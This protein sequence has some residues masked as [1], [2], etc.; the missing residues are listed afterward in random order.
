MIFNDKPVQQKLTK[1]HCNLESQ[2]ESELNKLLKAKIIFPIRHSK[3][4]SS[5]VPIQKNNGDIHICID[6]RNIVGLRGPGRGSDLF[7][8]TN[9]T[10]TSGP[11]GNNQ[12]STGYSL[13]RSSI[14]GS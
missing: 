4:V 5:L 8:P 2:I 11:S 1:I 3:W 10:L 7:M 6:F 12:H 9:K 14:G 13:T